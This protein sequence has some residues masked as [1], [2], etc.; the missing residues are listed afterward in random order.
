MNK[1]AFKIFKLASTGFC[2]SQ[3]MLKLALEEE[4]RENP[5]LIRAV[6]G[7]CNGIG[8]SQKTCGVLIGGIGI[9]GL[10]AGKGRETEYI[11]P[12]YGHMVEEY[13]NWF[14]E[15]FEATDCIDLIGVY[16]FKDEEKNEAYPIKC[17]DILLK[18]YEKI[19]EILYQQDY[20]LGCREE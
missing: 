19:N 4:E 18:S 1:I 11:K 12:D 16:N 13:M 5:D 14:E 20:E 3:I 8:S 9:L 2:C 7:L 17:G 10:Y 6:G 15:E